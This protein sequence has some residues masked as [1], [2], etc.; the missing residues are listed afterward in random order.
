[1]VHANLTVSYQPNSWCCVQETYEE[2]REG[3]PAG[4]V[5]LNITTFPLTATNVTY[6]SESSS[7]AEEEA[8]PAS[9]SSISSDSISN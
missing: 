5:C 7:S 1:M 3:K 2:D 8:R 9:T 4:L 6:S